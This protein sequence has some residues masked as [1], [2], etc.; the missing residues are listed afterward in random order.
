MSRTIVLPIT[1]RTWNFFLRSCLLVA[2]ILVASGLI[3]VIIEGAFY[4][5]NIVKSV[6]EYIQNN[7]PYSII[8]ICCIVVGII[9]IVV[10]KWDITITC[11]KEG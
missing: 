8:G 9:L 1:C 7:Y 11:K 10:M 6:W 2:A 5:P 3:I 4:V